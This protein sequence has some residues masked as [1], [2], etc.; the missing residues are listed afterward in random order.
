M[1]SSRHNSSRPT[2]PTGA[3]PTCGARRVVPV[4][5]D[6]VLRVGRRRYTIKK[7]SHKRCAACGE[8]MFGV[9]ASQR[10]DAEILSRRPRR[11][12]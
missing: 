5:D 2:R 4:V 12:A 8:R 11:A 1:S 10:F 7:V 9:E 3:C 6:V